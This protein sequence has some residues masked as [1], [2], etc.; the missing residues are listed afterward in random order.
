MQA[1]VLMLLALKPGKSQNQ[2]LITIK[3][4]ETRQTAAYPGSCFRETHRY[5]PGEK[6]GAGELVDFERW[7]P[8]S[9]RILQ[10]NVQEIKQRHQE[11]RMD[12]Q[13]ASDKT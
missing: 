9:S 6:T 1:E 10:P 8:P 3:A 7:P 4:K 2:A 5:G 11:S 12:E 13:G